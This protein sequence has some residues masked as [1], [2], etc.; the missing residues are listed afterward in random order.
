MYQNLC[1]MAR[2][3]EKQTCMVVHH[4][5][6]FQCSLWRDKRKFQQ[7][8]LLLVLFSLNSSEETRNINMYDKEDENQSRYERRRERKTVSYLC[9][10]PLNSLRQNDWHSVDNKS[11]L[12]ASLSLKLY[13]YVCLT[14]LEE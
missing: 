7:F 11:A 8:I 14:N 1:V 9:D 13:F 6:L 3:S 10:T 4:N 12:D 5:L 2:K